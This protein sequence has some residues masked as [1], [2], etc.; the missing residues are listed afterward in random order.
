MA[1]RLKTDWILFTTVLVMVAAGILIVYSA[2]SVM[3]QMDP[4][5][6]NSWHFVERQAAWGAIAIVLMMVLKNTYYR[7]LQ[8]PSVALSV[9]SI[10]LLLLLVVLV[11]DPVNRRWIR[12][13]PIGLQ[14]SELAKPALV[15]FLAFF[16]TWRARAINSARY[17]LIPA[18]MAVG[19][20]I[21]AVVVADLGTAIVIGAAAA[22]VFFVAGLEWRY[23]CI[24]AALAA[25]GLT[26][27][28]FTKT[29]RLARVIRF[30][31]PQF[32]IVQMFDPHGKLKARLEE[33]L[34]T[35]DTNYQLEQSRIAVGAGGPLG[36]GFMKGRQKLLYL[37][38]A[39]KDFI[40]AVA[41]EEMGVIGSVGL[42]IG[43]GLIFW[44]G[45]RATV[46]MRD[47]FGRY[48][49]L[50][51]TVVVVVQGLIHMSVV[52]GMMPTK[53]IPLPMISY[54]GSSL[55][56]TLMCLGMLMNVSEH[57]G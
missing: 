10:S 34:T 49:A 43:F 40:Y 2:S 12:F 36:L 48:L 55:V 4:H 31:D 54:G 51:L 37:P 41:G 8:D 57:A 42:L 9:I 24:V 29:Y 33:S 32:R 26:I 18:A 25:I 7:K 3:A 46:R 47:D 50:G 22:L 21:L 23:C 5:Y 1:Q 39:H 13:G 52:L 11:A 6:R 35:R 56:S 45:L 27:F 20:V 14:P 44:R 15:I 53:G 16:V 28:I 30:F 38:E 17:T 19:L